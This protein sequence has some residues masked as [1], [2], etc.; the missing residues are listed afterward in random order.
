[1]APGRGRALD[2]QA[3]RPTAVT[4][5]VG[6]RCCLRPRTA[7]AGRAAPTSMN[8]GCCS[9]PPTARTA[10]D[11]AV[12]M[13]NVRAP[14]RAVFAPRQVCLLRCARSI[15]ATSILPM[16][17]KAFAQRI[18]ALGADPA[19]VRQALMGGF[20]SSRILEVHGERMIKRSFNSGFRI[21]LHQKDL[22]LA[23]QGARDGGPVRLARGDLRRVEVLDEAGGGDEHGWAPKNSNTKNVP[24]SSNPTV[25]GANLFW[26]LNQPPNFCPASPGW[27][28]T[29]ARYERRATG[30]PAR[31]RT[32]RM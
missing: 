22:G 12:G 7:S 18:N 21:K 26:C 14:R 32:K 25:F 19:K 28:P 27:R 5:G 6:A 20:A 29:S 13:F 10:A 8:A 30:R 17:T 31:W 2:E 24:L 15:A 3:N 23:L 4:G 11:G 16:A 9:P 1:M